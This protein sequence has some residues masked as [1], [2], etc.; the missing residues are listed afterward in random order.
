M[1]ESHTN[2]LKHSRVFRKDHTKEPI[3]SLDLKG[4][5][6]L[7]WGKLVRDFKCICVHDGG[8]GHNTSE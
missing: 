1:E 8:K 3:V 6:G 5:P 4:L 2:F 7:A